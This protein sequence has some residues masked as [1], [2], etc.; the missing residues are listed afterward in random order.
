MCVENCPFLAV[1]Y[2]PGIA[3]DL[4]VAAATLHLNVL[5]LQRVRDLCCAVA[6]NCNCCF[7]TTDDDW[8]DKE[9]G[10]ID[11]PRIQKRAGHGS[12]AFEEHRLQITL[13]QFIEHRGQICTT[14]TQIGVPPPDLDGWGYA[15]AAGIGRPA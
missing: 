10:F 7:T 6:G 9:S 12:P 5:K 3:C 8:R 4:D 2:G 15:E 1:G 14:L 13:S 11:Q